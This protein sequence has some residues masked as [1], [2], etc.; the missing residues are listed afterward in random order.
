M[1]APVRA[2]LAILTSLAA[3]AAGGFTQTPLPPAPMVLDSPA[4]DLLAQVQVTEVERDGIWT[5]VKTFA[6]SLSAANGTQITISGYVVP[7]S[8]GEV[9]TQIVLVR[10][11]ADCPFCGGGYGPVLEVELDLGLHDMP[12]FS[13]LTVTG[14]LV[15]DA[16]GETTQAYRLVAARAE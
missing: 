15:L 8:P 16:S 7:L 6:P 10:D 1:T 13:R 3:G 12:E 5:V 14:K 9:L 11:P 2:T 4:W